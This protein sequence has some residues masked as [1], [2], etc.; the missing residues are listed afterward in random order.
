M[1]ANDLGHVAVA[2]AVVIV[3]VVV[4]TT[5]SCLSVQSLDPTLAERQQSAIDPTDRRKDSNRR[6]PKIWSSRHFRS[7]AEKGNGPKR[8]KC[9]LIF[10]LIFSIKQKMS[11]LFCK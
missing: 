4:V 8:N 9:D 7:L 6:R 10:L 1:E 5:G 3:M 2:V 11:P